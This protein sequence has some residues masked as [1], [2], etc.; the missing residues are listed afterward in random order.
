MI[1]SNEKP[2]KELDEQTKNLL[3][4]NDWEILLTQKFEQAGRPA[5]DSAQ[6]EKVWAQL[7]K[8]SLEL[9]AKKD[10]GVRDNTR[11]NFVKT[12]R[13]RFA[14]VG[15]VAAAAVAV[16]L[17]PSHK[18]ETNSLPQGVT[19]KGGG[20]TDGLPLSVKIEKSETLF[21][22]HLSSSYKGVAYVTALGK[23]KAT[24]AAKV[25]VPQ[26]SIDFRPSQGN[27]LVPLEVKWEGV[28]EGARICVLGSATEEGLSRLVALADAVW[29]ALPPDACAIF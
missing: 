16:V 23:L 17:L 9:S 8:Q 26:T 18:E 2:S 21:R 11:Q 22:L 13:A 20:S 10:S 5:A 1:D 3:N 7:Q 29:E 28:Q 4:E 19:L 27:S 12:L 14:L 6:K 24:D 15:L 25:V